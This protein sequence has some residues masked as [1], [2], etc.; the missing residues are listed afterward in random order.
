MNIR[1]I[2]EAPMRPSQ[3]IVMVHQFQLYLLA[4]TYSLLLIFAS[5]S[6]L[7]HEEK[8]DAN[9]EDPLDS[10]TEEASTSTSATTE[11]P[12]E[13]LPE[14]SSRGVIG[15][16]TELVCR[17]FHDTCNWIRF[18]NPLTTLTSHHRCSPVITKPAFWVGSCLACTLY[19]R[20][21]F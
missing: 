20:N 17:V 1:L 21:T 7:S 4:Q 13:A 9:Y 2:R 18:T 16:P 11:R 14:G 19:Y 5:S 8:E 3:R 15:I 6:P 12:P 10:D